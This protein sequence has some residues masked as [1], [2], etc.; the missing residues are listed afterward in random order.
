MAY[1]S[2]A[3][4]E[5][6]VG[7]PGTNALFVKLRDNPEEIATG[8]SGATRIVTAALTDALITEAKLGTGSVTSSKIGTGE[9]TATEIASSA[10]TQAELKSTTASQSLVISADSYGNITPTGGLYTLSYYLGNNRASPTSTQNMIIIGHETTY[11]AHV[12]MY[13]VDSV[14]SA[15]AYIYSRYIQ[16]SPPY[17]FG[18]GIVRKF[19]YAA[20]DNVTGDIIGTYSADDPP[21]AYHG[22]STIKPDYYDDEGRPI[23]INYT[24]KAKWEDLPKGDGDA[25]QN[26]IDDTRSPDNYKLK[27]IDND[28]KMIGMTEIPHPFINLQPIDLSNKTIVMIDPVDDFLTSLS[29]FQENENVSISELITEKYLKIDN[30]PLNRIVPN[31]CV[32][33]KARMKLT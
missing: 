30:S 21:W 22:N 1:S 9:V 2:I 27:I 19:V 33:V 29:I 8:G 28:Y 14:S 10:V 32:A 13:N 17:D 16:A 31:G 18:D 11:S 20:I 24:P 5:I 15:T 6:A 26:H 23:K 12:R 4:A 7:A 3:N 25:L